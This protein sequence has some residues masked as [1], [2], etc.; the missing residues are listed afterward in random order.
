MQESKGKDKKS[1]FTAV[2]LPA[3]LAGRDRRAA[4]RR[5]L[6]AEDGS[7]L[8]SVTLVMPGSVKA[9]RLS[10]AFLREYCSYL[11]SQFRGQNLT[12]AREE[13][14]IDSAGDAY[15]FLFTSGTDPL[16]LKKFAI[17]MEEEF[18]WAR[19]L[20][21]DLYLS[22]SEPLSRAGLQ[23][24]ERRCLICKEEA[25]ACSRSQCHSTS[26]LQEKVRQFQTEGLLQLL[27][28]RMQTAALAAALS[29]LLVAPKPGLVTGCDTGSHADM[30]RFT[31]ADSIA[32]LAG[33][34]QTAAK[35][36]LQVAL[37]GDPVLEDAA[38]K[39]GSDFIKKLSELKEAGLRA[40]RQM[41]AATGGVNTQKGF[42]YLGGLLLAAA[43]SLALDPPVF[44]VSFEAAG[45]RALIQGWQREIS[46]WALA[47][48]DIETS[49]PAAVETAGES[50]RRKYG[51][52]GVRGEAA[53]GMKSV[54]QLALPFYRALRKRAVAPN[55]SAV[56]TLV[57]LLAATEDTTLIKRAGLQ[58]AE[59][60]RKELA[61]FF[62]IM[63]QP[64]GL[65]PDQLP[66]D[67]NR[68]SRP[69]VST[70]QLAADA[71]SA[72]CLNNIAAQETA[73][74]SYISLWSDYFRDKAYSAGGAADLLAICLLVLKLLADI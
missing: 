66:D 55:E 8:L 47:L 69:A 39:A 29:E 42:I 7:C 67:L 44:A 17:T 9:T 62:H 18:D 13:A 58:Q 54:F 34:F 52:S 23:L 68:G 40:E 59:L 10:R 51:I 38:E 65:C 21:L 4:K 37:A 19:I 26:E 74:I 27:P 16:F 24:P 5:E 45:E 36:G 72:L 25:H 41:L 48:Q 6:L 33:Y 2:D 57:L 15:F 20:D 50:I 64:E 61:E 14:L 3:V 46:R 30:D 70:D 31:Y 56:V 32:A 28:G 11:R 1:L 63:S 53:G 73:V 43:A 71:L 35:C 12:L 49:S 60:I 22:E